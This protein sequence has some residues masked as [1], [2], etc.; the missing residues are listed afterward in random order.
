MHQ[1]LKE[2]TET[3]EFG[4]TSKLKNFYDEYDF[5][6]KDIR[7][8]PGLK[9]LEIGVQ[10]GG[11]LATWKKYF[12]D[13]QVT[14]VDIDPACKQFEANGV[15]IRIGSQDDKGFLLSVEKEFGPFDIIIDDGGHTMHQQIL[16]FETLYPLLKEEGIFVIEDIQT[17]YWSE[18]GGGYGRGGTAIEMIKNLIDRIHYAAYDNPRAG[19][20]HRFWFRL[21]PRDP[22]PAYSYDSSI[23]SISV[24]ESICFI[25]KRTILERYRKVRY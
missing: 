24:S 10:G 6:F 9:I 23:R 1:T 22:R 2:A 25:H 20:F 18:F 21:F 12:K 4:T 7:Q 19:I 17:S 11:S 3:R 15:N 13:P 8:R 5:H 16:T 14:G